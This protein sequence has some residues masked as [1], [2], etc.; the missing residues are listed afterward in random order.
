LRPT[1]LLFG[2]TYSTSAADAAALLPRGI[3]HPDGYVFPLSLEHDMIRIDRTTLRI[4][5]IHHGLNGPFSVGDLRTDIGEF[6]VKDQVLDAF[7]EGQYQATAW[8]SEIYLH[9]YVAVGRGVTELRAR[10][11][12][13]RVQAAS[14]SRHDPEPSE[15]DPI[16]ETNSL[17]VGSNL[18]TKGDG[19][20]IPPIRG[21]SVDITAFKAKP[22]N[23]GRRKAPASPTSDSV[24]EPHHLATLFG[25]ELWTRILERQ[26]VKLD[27]TVERS[28]FR[29]QVTALAALEY[30][31]NPM[32]QTFM[33]LA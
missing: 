11:H 26:P 9:Q 6:K 7:D 19:G 15:P 22:L 2:A 8:I 18:A 12:D 25:E 3:T 33:P 27:S 14:E 31:F 5:K 32:E 20:H 24:T 29:M 28:R 10:L 17:R 1:S 30:K 13:L 23:V 4:R 21:P 16:D